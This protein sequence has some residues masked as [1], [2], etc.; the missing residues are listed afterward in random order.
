MTVS[1]IVPVYNNARGLARC[2]ES[3]ARLQ[4]P[5]FEIIVVDDGSAER[6]DGVC[7]KY[8]ARLAR[9]A[10][11]A[12]A[13]VARNEGA[14][15]ARGK[16]LAFIDSDCAAPPDWLARIRAAMVDDEVVA[17]A[18][19]FGA[20]LGRNFFALLR[21]WEARYY[22]V[23]ERALVNSFVT[24]NFAIR[25][26]VFEKAGGF[27]PLWIAEDLIFGYRLKLLGYHALWLYD[28]EVAQDFRPSLA[29]YVKQQAEWM[30]HIFVLTLR[31]PGLQFMRWSVRKGG[32]AL[33]GGIEGLLLASLPVVAIVGGSTIAVPAALLVTLVALN[34]P[35]LRFVRRQSS[36]LRAAQVFVAVVAVRNP[37]WLMG[38]GRGF[39]RQPVRAVAGLYR[40]LLARVRGTA[41]DPIDEPVASIGGQSR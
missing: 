5:D 28:L 18:G 22:H 15:R 16:I 7:A 32:P 8:G 27:P 12:G 36:L 20:S 29:K 33:Q 3:L 41:P 30:E 13:G 10:T 26:T 14:R 35:F 4:D 17:V 1:V 38:V 21:F 24:A 9:L 25:T 39:L 40:L 31:Y 2:L 23:R 6:Y 19:T 34:W 11:N 37:A